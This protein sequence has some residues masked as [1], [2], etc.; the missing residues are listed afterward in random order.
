MQN[1]TAG[2]FAA[3][4]ATIVTQPTDVIRTH[5]QLG[6]PANARLGIVAIIRAI[7]NI[8]GAKALL[9]GAAPR[10]SKRCCFA[11]WQ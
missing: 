1:F 11:I 9:A 2:T 6:N 7:V 10:V 4:A 3:V 5:M 8:G